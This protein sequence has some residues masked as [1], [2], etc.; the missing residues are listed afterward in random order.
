MKLLL[1]WSI[2]SLLVIS[3]VRVGRLARDARSR[4][5]ATQSLRRL[6]PRRGSLHA[7]GAAGVVGP[8]MQNGARITSAVLFV[9]H[10]SAALEDIY[11]WNTVLARTRQLSGASGD[12][13]EYW[14]VCDNGSS[15]DEFSSLAQFRIVG[16]LDPWEMH[17]VAYADAADKVALHDRAGVVHYPTLYPRDP[18]AT[19]NALVEGI[20]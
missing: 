3:T 14:G 1:T 7:V 15:C 11:Y 6:L 19:A 9:V 18:N 8:R 20:R 5:Q 2:V 17:F 12:A 13:F 16:F 4:V 10:H